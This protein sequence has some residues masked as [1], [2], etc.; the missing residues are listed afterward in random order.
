MVNIFQYQN[1][2]AF[3]K[4][5][6]DEEKNANPHFSHR[7]ILM[8]MEVSS[9]GFLANVISGRNNLTNSH[10]SKLSKI[11]RLD[12]AQSQYFEWLGHFTQAKTMDEKNDYYLRMADLQKSKLKVLD[13]SQLSFFAKWHYSIIRELLNFFE[14]R[15]DYKDLA[16]RVDPPIRESEAREAV[17]ALEKMGLIVKDESGVYRQ[18][19][20]IISSGDE[21]SSMHVVNYQ[22]A[23]MDRAKRAL[24]KIRGTDRDISV[25]TM[26]LSDKSF[27]EIKSEV[28]QFRKKLLR[29]AELETNPDQ[30]FQLNINLFSVTK[31]K[32]M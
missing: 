22:L 3:L 15:D 5:F 8:R 7:A 11:L 21:V 20:A 29:I 9:S 1:Y 10:V 31:R 6:L 26:T 4:D 24:E 30:V 28:Q 12:K 18:K 2:R 27:R 19:E 13:A 23:T 25:L 17:A 32:E 16:R 14:F